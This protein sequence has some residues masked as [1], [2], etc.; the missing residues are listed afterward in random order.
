MKD[1]P[2]WNGHGV[3]NGQ[4]YVKIECRGWEM[5]PRA[6]SQ[7]WDNVEFMQVEHLTVEIEI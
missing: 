6:R 1:I 7:R 5:R 4:A 3:V 2:G